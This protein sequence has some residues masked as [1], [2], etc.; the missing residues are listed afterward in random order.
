MQRPDYAGGGFANL[1][2]SLAAACGVRTRLPELEALPARAAARAH[3]LVFL[4]LDGV[5]E[6][7]LAAHGAG[8]VLAAHRRSSLSAVFPS[9]TAAAV[10]TSFTAVS[11]AAHG[12]V[13]WFTYFGEAGCVGAALPFCVRAAGRPSLAT[14]GVRPSDLY[15][16]PPFFAAMKRRAVVVMGRDIVDS[17]YNSFHCAGA[18]RRAYTDLEGFV[19]AVEAAVRSG[20][21]PKFVYGYWPEF[22]TAAHRHGVASAAARERLSALDR[23]FAEL[24]ARLAGT[25]SL[26]VATAD[27]GFVDSTGPDALAL[28]DAPALAPLLRL[29]LCGE[30][31]VCLC[32]VQPGREREFAA[33]AR[34]WLDGRAEVVDSAALLA[35]GWF[36][37][38]PAHPRIRDRIGDVALLMR[39]CATL[40][41]R[42]P[43][44]DRHRLI[45]HHGGASE[46]EMRIPLIVAET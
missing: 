3:N 30:R 15:W 32:H 22:D 28:E 23:A 29:P 21:E 11:P 45:G 9:T 34:A 26:V 44:E 42:V 35:E 40:A 1:V 36:G 6:A 25:D 20:P 14:R 39:G 33:R 2:A 46:D 16:T 12:L 38:G 10:T 19:A 13:G 17:V 7:I 4:L 43:G 8:G 5:G 24:L 18:E 41:D 31:R 27:H 37:P